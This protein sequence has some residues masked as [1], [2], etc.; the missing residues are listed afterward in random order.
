[1]TPPSG[2]CSVNC[3]FYDKLYGVFSIVLVAGLALCENVQVSYRLGGCQ[4]IVCKR[5]PGNPWVDAI[6]WLEKYNIL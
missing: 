4:G 6:S 2:T 1:M 3:I 5:Q